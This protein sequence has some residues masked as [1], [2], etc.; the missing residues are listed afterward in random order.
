MRMRTR[1]DYHW[2]YSSRKLAEYFCIS[3]LNRVERRELDYLK[4]IQRKKSYRRIRAKEFMAAIEKGLHKLG[5]NR[6]LGNVFTLP[7]TF[8]GS[9][10][11]YQSKYADLMTV[12]QK[13]G[14]P[15]WFCRGLNFCL[16][17]VF[18]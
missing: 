2:L 13:L 9:R 14:N 3:A 5:P 7:Q 17:F 18:V 8:A 6:K 4:M 15:T 16:Y 10:Q 11:Y 1:D 12:V